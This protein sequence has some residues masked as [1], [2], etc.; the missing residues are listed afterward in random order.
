MLIKT[1]SKKETKQYTTL[2][3]IFYFGMVQLHSRAD[4]R[5]RDEFDDHKIE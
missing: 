1:V 4:H 5:T 3:N 2:N